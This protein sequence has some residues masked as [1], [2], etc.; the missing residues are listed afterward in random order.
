MSGITCSV[1]MG[2]KGMEALI[3]LGAGDMRRTLNILQVG[4][5][6]QV[7]SRGGSTR[8]FPI[9]AIHCCT[10]CTNAYDPE[11]C[12]CFTLAGEQSVG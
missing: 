5:T 11:H 10:T 9:F 6:S 7:V 2:E 3:N 12:I 8:V 1:K 4:L